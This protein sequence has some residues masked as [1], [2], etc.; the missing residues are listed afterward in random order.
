MSISLSFGIFVSGA[1]LGNLQGD[2]FD[3]PHTNPVLGVDVPYGT[4][5]FWP[6]FYLPY[7]GQNNLIC[8]NI[9][10][11][12]QTVADSYTI[13]CTMKQNVWFL[14]GICSENI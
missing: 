14:V 11:V 5:N 7:F 9:A 1:D 3:I 12:W 2:F 8:F 6:P 13:T 10:D 4:Y